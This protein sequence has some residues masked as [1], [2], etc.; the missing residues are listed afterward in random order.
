[1]N[2]KML[3]SLLFLLPS[4]GLAQGFA[5]L[6]QGQDGFSKPERGAVFSFPR[7][8]GAHPDFRIEWWYL[9]ANLKDT[10]GRDLGVQWTLFRSAT[11]PFERL[12]W[13]SP[14]FWLA[15]AALTTPDAH[16]HAEK[17]SRG[18]I[19]QAGVIA[20]PFAAWI[21]DWQMAG[22]DFDNLTLRAD[23]ER[24]SY[25]L[26]LKAGGPLVFQ[27]DQGYSVKSS[28]GQA[29]YYYSQPHY[30][31]SGQVVENGEIID[32]IGTAWLDRE[33]SSQPLAADQSGWDW[34]SLNFDDGSKLMG[35][36]L[37]GTGENFT[38]GTWIDADGGATPLPHGAFQAAPR[39][40]AWDKNKNIP[41]TWS[42]KLPQKDVDISV[43]A[44]NPG[45]W[46]DTRF[47]YWEGPVQISGSHRG[48][49]YLEM[50]GYPD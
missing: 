3:M 11:E 22:Q 9:T 13:Q 6:G 21:D 10:S 18:G 26:M 5:G 46:M 31:V 27:G 39:A 16:Y 28:Q 32:V 25:D 47:S 41:T 37:R 50:T 12:D 30:Q 24:F 29:S 44:L 45:S 23:G 35:F 34:F 20:D 42:V 8:H 49:G 40:Y 17:L 1:M 15:H 36:V 43:S 33:W 4:L 2:V 38:S 7:D 14:Q 48:R 19:G